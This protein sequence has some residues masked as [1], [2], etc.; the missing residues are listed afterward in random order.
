M[1]FGKN[2]VQYEDRFWSF[3]KFKNFDTYFY[4]GG[5]EL[6]I[7]T[8]RTATKDLE[9]IEKL[10]DYKLDGRLQFVIYDKLSDAKQSNIGLESIDENQQN[11]GGITKI[12][13]N[14]IFLYFTGDHEKLHEQIRAGIARV[15]IDQIMYGGSVK[16]RLQNSALLN[17]PDWYLNGLISYISRRWDVEIDNRVRDNIVNKKYFKFNHLTGLDAVYAGH[18]VWKYVVDTYGETSISNLLYM[19]RINRNIESGFLFV[20]G[21]S[22]STLADNWKEY[23]LKRYADAD[24]NRTLPTQPSLVKKPKAKLIYNQLKISPDGR[25]AAYVTN[26]MGKYKVKLL[27][28]SEKKTR[29]IK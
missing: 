21:A 7:F 24:A 15:L 6:A 11:I 27:D 16:D 25:Y 3:Y 13:G 1:T 26:D 10:L 23:M 29:R 22:V 2:R 8:G 20:I 9:E 14:K 28:I 18:S 12:V 17:L 5:K 19:T 4:I